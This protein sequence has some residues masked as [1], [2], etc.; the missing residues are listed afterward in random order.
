VAC[1][2]QTSLLS[3]MPTQWRYVKAHHP[4]PWM[5]LQKPP[6]LAERIWHAPM[7]HGGAITK[8]NAQ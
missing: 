3:G 1:Q 2:R 5:T 6:A 8:K 7:L 4:L